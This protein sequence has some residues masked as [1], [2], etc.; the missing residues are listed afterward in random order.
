MNFK[1]HKK[2]L[3]DLKNLI[4]KL[5]SA[6]FSKKNKMLFGASIGEHFRHIIEFYSCCLSQSKENKVNYDLRERNK[7]LELDIPKGIDTINHIL[8]TLEQLKEKDDQMLVFNNY[9]KEKDYD[10]K[11]GLQSSFF[12]ELNYCMDH[13]IHHQSLIKIALL[14]QEL[15]YLVDDNFGVAFSTQNYRKGCVS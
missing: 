12:R 2:V 7:Q 5:D 9:I 8:K 4:E 10:S 6:S 13:C 1:P 15:I 11:C 3:T 14:E